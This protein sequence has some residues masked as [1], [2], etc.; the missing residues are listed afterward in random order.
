MKKHPLLPTTVL[1]LALVG[2]AI[3]F[4]QSVPTPN[5]PSGH[6]NLVEAQQLIK[7]AYQKIEAAQQYNKA[8]LGGHAKKAEQLLDQANQ[9]LD[10]A[11]SYADQHQDKHH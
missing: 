11:A 8:E 2:A 7:Q 10:A 5:A 6:H 4:S 3:G 1:A 9:E